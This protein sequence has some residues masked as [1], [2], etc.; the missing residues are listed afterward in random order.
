MYRYACV[1]TYVRTGQRFI[2]GC[3]DIND[4]ETEKAIAHK[5]KDI[6]GTV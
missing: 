3:L 6:L 2:G 1:F 5:T 4:T